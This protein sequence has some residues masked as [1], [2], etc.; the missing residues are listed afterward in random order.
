MNLFFQFTLL[1]VLL[2]SLIAGFVFLKS[3]KPNNSAYKYALGLAIGGAFLLFWINGAVGLIGSEN[4]DVNMMYPL[5]IVLLF[6][7][8]FIVKFQPRGMSFILRMAA[9]AQVIIPIVAVS[10]GLG[11]GQPGWPWFITII[12]AFFTTLWA[13]SATLFIKA[14]VFEGQKSEDSE[15]EVS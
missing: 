4:N 10:I 8:S 14:H 9:V 15:K 5:L 11:S 12:T 1:G 6:L 13:G 7:G 2:A 3:R